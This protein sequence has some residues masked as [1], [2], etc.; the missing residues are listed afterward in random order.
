MPSFAYQAIDAVTGRERKGTVEGATA[1]Q[2]SAALKAK[3]LA[4]VWLKPASP[5]GASGVTAAQVAGR[6]LT[7]GK[8]DVGSA[9]AT[10]R[11]PTRVLFGR[12]V[13]A[14]RLAVF[15]RQLATLIKAGMPLL[16]AV[17]V[18]ARQENKPEFRWVLEEIADAI[19]SGGSLSQALERHPRIFDRLYL[20]MA[21][22][23]EA[24]GVLA[25]VLD[26]VAVFL[27]KAERVRGRIKAAMMYPAIVMLVAGGIVAGLMVFVVPKFEAIFA[28]LLKGQP[29]PTLTQA[30]LV[31][32]EFVQRQWLLSLLLVA[33]VAVAFTMVR[34]TPR[35]ARWMDG[36]ALR[37]PVLGDLALKGAV[38]RFTRTFGTLLS[39]GVPMLQA[40]AITR[41]ACGNLRVAEAIDFVHDR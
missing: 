2:A 31:A 39:S 35:G 16:R 34:R 15:T 21:R 33:V 24:G 38:A 32:S 13:T 17:E 1:E 5:A 28:G 30:V 10:T 9:R 23:G 22:A 19:R 6:S 36:I 4:P 40:L 27:E 20:S 26:R 41:D 8:K 14:K 25:A 37:I 12:V 11:K 7:G 29:L 18:L 3:G